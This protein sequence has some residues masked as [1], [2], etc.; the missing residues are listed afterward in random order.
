M[1]IVILCIMKRIIKIAIYMNYKYINC[2]KDVSHFCVIFDFH[3][4]TNMFQGVVPIMS[5]L[6]HNNSLSYTFVSSISPL[7]VF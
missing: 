5:T 1:L 6:K 2:F 7:Q 4:K 3:P